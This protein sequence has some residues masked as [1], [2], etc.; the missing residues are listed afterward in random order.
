VHRT[1]VRSLGENQ[2]QISTSF[3]V[4]VRVFFFI[5]GTI[6]YVITCE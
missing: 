4:F 2:I 6:M 3:N 5:I 1:C